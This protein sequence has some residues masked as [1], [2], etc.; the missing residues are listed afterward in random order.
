M[1]PFILMVCALTT[2]IA[3]SIRDQGVDGL[4]VATVVF[5]IIAALVKARKQNRSNQ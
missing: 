1:I 4:W 3:A 2:A 5:I